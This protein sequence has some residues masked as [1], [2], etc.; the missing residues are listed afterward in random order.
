MGLVFWPRRGLFADRLVIVVVPLARSPVPRVCRVVTTV[1]PPYVADVGMQVVQEALRCLRFGP[2][3]KGC[4]VEAL[5]RKLHPFVHLATRELV[6]HK[7]LEVDHER[8]RGAPDR[9]S[10]ARPLVALAH[11]AEPWV[12]LIQGLTLA[13]RL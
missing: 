8:V 9:E 3:H 6:E 1:D 7:P 11:R 12:V 10:L 4:Q 2:R 5:E 13:E